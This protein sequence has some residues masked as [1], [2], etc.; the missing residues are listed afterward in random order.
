MSNSVAGLL[1]CVILIAVLRRYDARAPNHRGIAPD[2]RVHTESDETP[3]RPARTRTGSHYS[4]V[5]ETFT[6]GATS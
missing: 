2:D 5:L 3:R 4:S 6:I 1:A